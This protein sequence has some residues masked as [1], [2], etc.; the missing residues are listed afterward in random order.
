MIVFYEVG[1]IGIIFKL[2]IL[3]IFIV[4]NVD[5]YFLVFYV[6][7]EVIVF[8]NVEVIGNFIDGYEVIGMVDFN[9]IVCIYD[10]EGNMIVEG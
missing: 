7:E 1:F 9:V 3:L 5:G 4:L 10:D 8:Y 6:V 2:D